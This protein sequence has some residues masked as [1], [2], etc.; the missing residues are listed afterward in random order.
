VVSVTGDRGDG[1]DV[2]GR[3]EGGDR[4][5]GRLKK[6]MLLQVSLRDTRFISWLWYSCGFAFNL[7]FR[8]PC[9]PACSCR[10]PADVAVHWTAWLFSFLSSQNTDDVEYGYYRQPFPLSQV[11]VLAT[12]IVARV[13]H[14][15]GTCL[16]SLSVLCGCMF[17]ECVCSP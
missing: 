13:W 16:S 4:G 3:R 17:A 11:Q 9:A 1:R 8:T 2:T 15:L 5:D 12:S 7:R 6:Q 10:V 14:V